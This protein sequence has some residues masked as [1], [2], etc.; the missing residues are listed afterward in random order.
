MP[1]YYFYQACLVGQSVDPVNIRR[2]NETSKYVVA[3]NMEG[4][5]AVE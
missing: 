5:L 3:E 1:G 2:R 4:H